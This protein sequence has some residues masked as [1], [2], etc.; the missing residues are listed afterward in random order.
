MHQRRA[1]LNGLLNGQNGLEHLVLHLDQIAGFLGGLLGFGGDY[2]H[3]VARI[4]AVIMQ[5]G[6]NGRGIDTPVF[7]L[8]GQVAI[9]IDAGNAGHLERRVDIHVLDFSAGIGAAQH[10]HVQ[11]IL[12]LHVVSINGFTGNDFLGFQTLYVFAEIAVFWLVAHAFA[13]PLSS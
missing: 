1:G 7:A 13:S 10:L 4:A 11:K 5:H 9:V 8:L 6:H 12:K 2:R 3:H